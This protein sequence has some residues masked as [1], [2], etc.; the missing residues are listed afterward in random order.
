MTKEATKSRYWQPYVFKRLLAAKQTR[1]I[2]SIFLRCW[3]DNTNAIWRVENVSNYQTFCGIDPT[4]RTNEKEGSLNKKL[5]Q[6][7]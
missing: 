2:S 4:W 7:K 1:K 5:K 6:H 3:F